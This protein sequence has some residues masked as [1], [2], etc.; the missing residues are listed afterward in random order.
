M[1]TPSLEKR[2]KRNRPPTSSAVITITATCCSAKITPPRAK[3]PSAKGV[4]KV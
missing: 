4:G 3:V 1:A 2:K